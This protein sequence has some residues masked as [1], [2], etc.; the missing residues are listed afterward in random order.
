MPSPG[1]TACS[2]KGGESSAGTKGPVATVDGAPISRVAYD[3]YVKSVSS[4]PEDKLTEQQRTGLLENLVRAQLLSKVAE[5]EGIANDEATR[6]VLELHRWNVLSQALS[7]KFMKEHK[8][9]D[10][11]LRAEYGRQVDTMDKQQ[12]RASHILV[13][14]EDEAK[15]I[16]E[17]LKGG[18]NFAAIARA[19]SLDTASKEKGGDLDW[20]SPGSMVPE[21]SQAV[22][23]LKKGETSQTP[24]GTQYGWH[25]L[26]VTDIRDT[27]PPPYESV[28]G[29]LEE[30]V[31]GKK[32][33]AYVDELM[34]KA[35]I[36]RS[37]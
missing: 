36:T 11:E 4:N 15:K 12:Y 16:I 29:R 34:A 2:P 18:A 10:D 33:K 19:V 8:V 20:F 28:K 25:V 13:K 37:L 9:T 27:A 7:E 5:R 26:R 31:Q 35:K 6:A 24:V 32:F 23:S 14:S 21:F 30:L 17:Q 3:E 1:L 22:R